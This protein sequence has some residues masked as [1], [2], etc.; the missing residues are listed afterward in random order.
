MDNRQ[1]V[2]RVETFIS[3]SRALELQLPILS[4]RLTVPCITINKPNSYDDRSRSYGR[5]EELESSATEGVELYDGIIAAQSGTAQHVG[6]DR[7]P[8]DLRAV[9]QRDAPSAQPETAVN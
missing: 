3:R 5:P 1:S 6:D 9:D 8:G 7:A 2:N 4:L